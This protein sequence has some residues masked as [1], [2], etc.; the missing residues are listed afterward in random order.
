MRLLQRPLI[1]PIAFS[2]LV[3]A[4][5]CVRGQEAPNELFVTNMFNTSQ[6]FR[7]DYCKIHKRVDRNELAVNQSLQGVAIRSAIS[8]SDFFTLKDGKLDEDY[9]GLVAVLLDELC[10]RAGCTWRD[11]FASVGPDEAK[12][13]TWDDMMEGYTWTDLLLWTIETYDGKFNLNLNLNTICW[14]LVG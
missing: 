2:I 3:A 7:Q 10:R 14:L 13:E 6:T 9:P 8:I 11:S 4:V 1:L 12:G 5:V